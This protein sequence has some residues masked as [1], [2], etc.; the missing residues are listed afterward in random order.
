MPKTAQIQSSDVFD[1]E[2]DSEVVLDMMS[3]GANSTQMM[4]F[5]EVVTAREFEYESITERRRDA[6]TNNVIDIENPGRS[7]AYEAFMQEPVT[8]SINE[9]ADEK[10]APVVYVCVNGDERWL[11]RGVPLRLQRKFVEILAQSNERRFMTGKINASDDTDN[12]RPVKSKLTQG[13]PFAVLK[14]SN[15]DGR[16]ARR[17][18]LRVTKQGR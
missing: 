12:E 7:L 17:W 8:I 1:S 15:P 3:T 4:R 9:S 11:P 5:M 16:L 14:D 13:T 10:A 18:L 6:S 2:A